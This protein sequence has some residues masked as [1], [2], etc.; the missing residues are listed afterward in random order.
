MY[1]LLALTGC[2]G[3]L[4]MT[5]GKDTI[6]FHGCKSFFVYKR[7]LSFKDEDGKG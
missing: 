2:L 1:L 3:C 4:R 6:F 7:C 5:S